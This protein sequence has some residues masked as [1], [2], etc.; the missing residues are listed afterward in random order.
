MIIKN[1]KKIVLISIL[2]FITSSFS[3]P[4]RIDTLI[5]K[6]IERT[7][8]IKSFTIKPIDITN[9]INKQLPLKINNSNFKEIT[10]NSKLLG[11][12]YHGKAFGKVDYFDFL[13][14]FDTNL[15]IKK[16]KILIYR[17]DRGS[18]IGSKRWLKQFIG[19]SATNSFIYEKDIVGISG[20]TISAKSM[21]SKIDKLMQSIQ[22]LSKNKIL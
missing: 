15:V 7:F 16:I 4:K 1:I 13:V 3:I 8:N 9:E 5:Q 17:E 6:E 14:I 10:V 21:T 19:K 20:A 11:Y 12:Y 2:V 18:E 22:I